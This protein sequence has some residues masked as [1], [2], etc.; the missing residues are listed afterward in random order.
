MAT[1]YQETGT[2]LD[3]KASRVYTG[4]LSKYMARACLMPQIRSEY[5]LVHTAGLLPRQTISDEGWRT[6][7]KNYRRTSASLA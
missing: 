4:I 7:S 6:M 2:A 3:A 1:K 5:E